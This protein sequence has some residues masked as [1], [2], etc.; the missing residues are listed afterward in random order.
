MQTYNKMEPFSGPGPHLRSFGASDGQAGSGPIIRLTITRLTTMKSAIILDETLPTGLLANA[1]ACI[2]TGLF[3]IG[4]DDAYGP[5]IEGSDCTFIPITQIPIL[6]LKKG[7][8]D[9]EEIIRRIKDN[10]VQYMLFTR[11]AQSTADYEEY[12][13]RVD[14]KSVADLTITGIGIIGDDSAV[15]KIAG[16]LPLLRG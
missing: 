13:R 7:K 3:R 8:R 6:I 16:D 9:F 11:E 10:E 4:G 5:A 15:T 1:A 2:A 12:V 14:G